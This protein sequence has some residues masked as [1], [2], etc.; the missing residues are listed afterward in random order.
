MPSHHTTHLCWQRRK[1]KREKAEG[2]GTFIENGGASGDEWGIDDVA[3][4][5]HLIKHT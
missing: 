1:K 4:A 5:N 2:R 3:V